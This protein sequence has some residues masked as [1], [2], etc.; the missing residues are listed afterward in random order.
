MSK[1]TI[2]EYAQELRDQHEQGLI[3]DDELAESLSLLGITPSL[4]KKVEHVDFSQ[5]NY[6]DEVVLKL[7]SLYHRELFG[8]KTQDDDQRLQNDVIIGLVNDQVAGAI[9]YSVE[10]TP[11]YNKCTYLDMFY[12]VPEFRK[13]GIASKLLYEMIQ[14]TPRDYCIQT[15]AWKP[16]ISFYRKNGF[17]TTPQISDKEEQIF[18]RMVLPLTLRSFNRY[19]REKKGVLFE[20]LE[21]VLEANDNRFDIDFLSPWIDA[22]KNFEVGCEYQNNPFTVFLYQRLGK[23]HAL[24]D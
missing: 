15:Y 13:T 12:I 23:Q 14:N 3:S 11:D 5:T 8:R 24:L 18:Q 7:E 6:E 1:F 17:F 9:W 21:E 2:K 10:P 19:E 4:T 16:V 20:G 22:I